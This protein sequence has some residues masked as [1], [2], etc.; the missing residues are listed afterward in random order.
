MT[1]AVKFYEELR[2]GSSLPVLV[3]GDDRQKYVVKLNGAGD[4]VLS[5]LVEWVSSKLGEALQLPILQ[6]FLV[7]IDGNLAR[8]PGDP[9]TRELL[10]RSIGVNLATPYLPVTSLYTTHHAG[11]IDQ[12]LRQRIFLF[13]VFLLNVDRTEQNPNMIVHQDQLWCLDYSSAIEIR[14]LINNEPF[15]EHT[16]LKHLKRHPFYDT[17]LSPYDFMK[18]LRQVPESTIRAIVASI[19]AEWTGS[20]KAAK[21]GMNWRDVVTE[22][23]IQKKEN[24]VVVRARL[25]LLRIL[26]AETAEALQA[27]TLRNK[28]NF[29][30]KYGK[31]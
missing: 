8:Q 5:H 25:D 2:R 29:E 24:G 17:S 28:E 26:Q 30:K 20:L 27:R 31:F 14:S 16:L 15:R 6:P 13:D 11:K 9:E 23:L 10:E 1:R 21:P 3:G 22:K 19:P 4:G 7:L 12:A 18:R